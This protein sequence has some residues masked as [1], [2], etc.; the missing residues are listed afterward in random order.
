MCNEAENEKK[1]SDPIILKVSSI[2]SYMALC[3]LITFIILRLNRELS[4]FIPCTRWSEKK[5]AYRHCL[6]VNCLQLHENAN[7]VTLNWLSFPNSHISLEPALRSNASNV[8]SLFD[9]E[10]LI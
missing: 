10:Y 7:D 9:I 8:N 1:N 4:Q 5:C 3:F 2:K 6:D